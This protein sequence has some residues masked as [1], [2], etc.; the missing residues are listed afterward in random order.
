[1]DFCPKLKIWGKVLVKVKA[2]TFLDE[3]EKSATNA[4]KT[5]SKK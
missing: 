4:I 5:A 1:M 2:R 3:V